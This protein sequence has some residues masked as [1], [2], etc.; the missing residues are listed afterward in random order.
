MA[1]MSRA[2][3]RPAS[4][5]KGKHK[6]RHD[7]LVSPGRRHCDALDRCSASALCLNTS[8]VILSRVCKLG[9]NFVL[10]GVSQQFFGHVAARARD[11]IRIDQRY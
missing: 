5:R 1:E 7:L 9:F 8:V 6:E 4:A 11:N 2:C 10:F 3:C